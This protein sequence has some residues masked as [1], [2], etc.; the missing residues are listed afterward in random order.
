MRAAP[1][2][3]DI[4]RDLAAAR[5]IDTIRELAGRAGIS[6]WVLYKALRQGHIR[7]SYAIALAETLGVDG[8]QHFA[9]HAVAS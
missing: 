9:P 6:E 1:I 2:D 7:P 5:G 3:P 4:L 8:P